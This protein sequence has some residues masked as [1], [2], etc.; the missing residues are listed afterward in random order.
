MHIRLGKF[1]VEERKEENIINITSIITTIL[2]L[3][4]I[5]LSLGF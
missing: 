3:G 4:D 2:L 5:K 1:A